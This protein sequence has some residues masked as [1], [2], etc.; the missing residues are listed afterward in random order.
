M[1]DQLP[2]TII[3]KESVRTKL[4]Y[5]DNSLCVLSAGS[6]RQRPI[7]R[8]LNVIGHIKSL[9]EVKV[10]TANMC[11]RLTHFDSSAVV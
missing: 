7:N 8:L 10:L 1:K 4:I 5:I 11:E 3:S 9:T 6:L 2:V